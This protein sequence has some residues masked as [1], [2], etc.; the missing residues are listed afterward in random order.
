[1]GGGAGSAFEES[2]GSS[3]KLFSCRWALASMAWDREIGTGGVP[4]FSLAGVDIALPPPLVFKLE[5][6]S[7][8]P[9]P[10]RA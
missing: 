2:S 10:T 4:G 9:L 7:R 6:V 8:R 3:I 5:A 1:M